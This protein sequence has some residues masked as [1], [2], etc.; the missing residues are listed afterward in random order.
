MRHDELREVD[1]AGAVQEEVEV[2]GSWAVRF[3]ARKPARL[4]LEVLEESEQIERR[5][6]G[7]AGGDG[8]QEVGLWRSAHGFGD[9]DGGEGESL[10]VRREAREGC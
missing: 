7:P 4:R 2:E 8:V 10:E 9:V 1:P 3:V 6:A 5:Q